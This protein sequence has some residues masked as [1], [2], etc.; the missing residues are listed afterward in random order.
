MLTGV[1]AIGF[2]LV[3]PLVTR[4]MP[5]TPPAVIATL[6]GLAMLRVLQ[7][8]VGDACRRFCKR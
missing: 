6:A 5:S 2:G 1:L 7:H 4:L 3:A 8:T